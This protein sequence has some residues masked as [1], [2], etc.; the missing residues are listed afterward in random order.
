MDSSNGLIHRITSQGAI[1]DR[2]IV[3]ERLWL[4]HRLPGDLFQPAGMRGTKKLQDFLVDEKISRSLRDSMPL[5][6]SPQGVVWVAG[7]R[8]AEWAR[9]TK[10]SSDLLELWLELNL[11]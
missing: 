11:P 4:R 10:N 5:L 2:N 7:W 6:D 9:P 8:V 3:G 1:V